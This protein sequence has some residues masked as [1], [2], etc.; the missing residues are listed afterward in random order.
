MMGGEP[1]ASMCSVDLANTGCLLAME[2]M[3]GRVHGLRSAFPFHFRQSGKRGDR[4]DAGY[5][6]GYE[7]GSQQLR[8][9]HD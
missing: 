4:N 1:Y 3:A 2:P 6:A 9:F 7:G 5:A 8:G